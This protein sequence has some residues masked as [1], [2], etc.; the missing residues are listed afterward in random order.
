M[1]GAGRPLEKRELIGMVIG[2]GVG[3]CAGWILKQWALFAMMGTMI[4]FLAGGISVWAN[5]R[6]GEKERL[7]MREA[8]ADKI[9]DNG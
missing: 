5:A 6:T 9:R 1:P 4:G 7:H 2:A 3:A 8:V